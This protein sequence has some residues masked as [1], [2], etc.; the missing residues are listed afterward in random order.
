MSLADMDTEHIW[1][2]FLMYGRSK[3]LTAAFLGIGN[4]KL[5]KAL[6]KRLARLDAAQGPETAQAPDASPRPG[7]QENRG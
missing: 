2:A 7:G 3:K 4:G 5:N 1:F 6:K